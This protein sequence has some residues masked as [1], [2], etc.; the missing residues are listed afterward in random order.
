[1]PGAI[2]GSSRP[3]SVVRY[4]PRDTFS[5]RP[6]SSFLATSMVSGR[7]VAAAQAVRPTQTNSGHAEKRH[8]LI[9]ASLQAQSYRSAL[10]EFRQSLVTSPSSTW[11]EGRTRRHEP[12]G[13]MIQ[14]T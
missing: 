11:V 5:T 7:H 8:P 9:I 13:G 10:A 1:M 6:R 4:N 3:V 12:Q 14:D 2:A